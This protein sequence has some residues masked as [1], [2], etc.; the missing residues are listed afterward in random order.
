MSNQL[1]NDYY[2]T[3][4]QPNE[5]ERKYI[6]V[7]IVGYG[8]RSYNVFFDNL[9]EQ[10]SKELIK[11][12]AKC[13]YQFLGS[14]SKTL[15]KDLEK[16]KISNYDAII[17]LTQANASYIN[18]DLY[19]DRN[20]GLAAKSVKVETSLNI[21]IVEK[22]DLRSSVVSGKM[23]ANVNVKQTKIYSKISLSVIDFFKTN[24]ILLGNSTN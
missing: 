22:K 19:Y 4:R 16:E 18:E 6:N 13:D 10:L 21:E 14:D 15:Q 3:T 17:L 9:S 7:Y 5:T 12:G 23:F 20:Y 24:K 8:G 11:I 2:I 1:T